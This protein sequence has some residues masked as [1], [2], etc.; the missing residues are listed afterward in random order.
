MRFG[1]FILKLQ[2]RGLHSE[3]QTLSDDLSK[4]QGN[5]TALVRL[6]DKWDDLLN[7]NPSKMENTNR[8]VFVFNPEDNGGE[9]FMVTTEI[10]EDGYMTQ[11]ISL[12]SYGAAASFNIPGWMTP[13]KLRDLANKL[14]FFILKSQVLKD[15]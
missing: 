11:E 6:R 1:S 7:Y 5:L 4:V 3:A 8:H 15:E 9:S 12:Q 14:D 13:E 2:G 10:N